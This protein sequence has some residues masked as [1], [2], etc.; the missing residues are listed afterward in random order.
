MDGYEVLSAL[1]QEPI[2]AHIPFVFITAK[3]EKTDIIYGKEA[4]ADDYLVKPFTT[5]D[6]LMAI[7]AC[8][9]KSSDTN[10]FY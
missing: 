9:Q 8:L 2:T 5:T 4:G 1:R 6:L 10:G 7:E 3:A